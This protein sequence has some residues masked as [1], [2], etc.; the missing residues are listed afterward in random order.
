MKD[1]LDM[2]KITEMAQSKKLRVA[3]VGIAI[4]VSTAYGLV[5]SN[6]A[7]IA[8][9]AIVC[10]YEIGQGLAD[11]GKGALLPAIEFDP[12]DPVKFHDE[13]AAERDS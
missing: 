1:L 11:F 2:L 13:I 6:I 9:A 5:L 10:A 12:V 4:I 7:I 8:I 3:T